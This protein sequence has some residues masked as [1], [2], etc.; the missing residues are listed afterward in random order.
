MGLIKDTI[1]R[2]PTFFQGCWPCPLEIRHSFGS[3]RS[4][5]S[6]GLFCV[7]KSGLNPMVIYFVLWKGRC[8]RKSVLFNLLTEQNIHFFDNT[9]GRPDPGV[10]LTW[11]VPIGFLKSISF[12]CWDESFEWPV[13]RR[14]S[15]NK[16][17]SCS[18][19][20][21]Y[22]RHVQTSRWVFP[23]NRGTPKW[24]VYNGKPY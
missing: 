18:T 13:Y 7:E 4:A 12:E 15:P 10:W 5:D 17:T 11:V 6:S 9:W 8:S 20:F 3:P 1:S 21:T 22:V 14:S 16:K 23:K 24:M 2:E 19:E